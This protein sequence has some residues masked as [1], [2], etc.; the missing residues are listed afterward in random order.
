M[1]GIQIWRDD[2]MLLIDDEGTD[3]NRILAPAKAGH[4]DDQAKACCVVQMIDNGDLEAALAVELC[5]N[6]EVLHDYVKKYTTWQ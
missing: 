5:P 1:F 3:C 2:W 6:D 4:S